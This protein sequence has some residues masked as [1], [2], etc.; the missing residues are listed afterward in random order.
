MAANR[1]I[2]TAVIGAGVFGARHAEKHALLHNAALVA[3]VDHDIGR[4]EALAAK[5]GAA[6]FADIADLPPDIEAA[7][8]ACTT[9]AHHPV[10]MALIERGVHLLIEKPIADTVARGVALA[11]A[12]E[13]RGLVLQVGHIERYSGAYEALRKRVTTPLFVECNRIAP[14]TGRSSDVNVV[15]D[16]MIHDIDLIAALVG[17]PVAEIAAV[18]APVLT[19]QEDIANAR[20]TF[21]TGCVA[22]IT[23]SRVSFKTE[24]RLRI[25]QPD[26]YIS[27][28][29]H[30]RKINVVR[31]LPAETEGGER[32]L[33]GEEETLPQA[34][35]LLHEIDLFLKA[36]AEGGRPRVGARDGVEALR[37]ALAIGDKLRVHRARLA[38]ALEGRSANA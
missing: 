16:L 20:I 1:T 5:Y 11:E 2:R 18:G 37:T 34:D 35:N 24:R 13:A 10:G 12:A 3:I 14:F 25:F 30:A 31:R 32:A 26:A 28:D 17:A 15:L 27:A 7:S 36:V 38:E 29:L 8:V 19:D 9:I 4:A 33:S 22:N 23:A 6:A 21:E